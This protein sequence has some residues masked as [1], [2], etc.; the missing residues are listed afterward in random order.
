MAPDWA[1]DRR[2]E[3]DILEAVDAVEI[4]EW[5]SFWA[6]PATE[7]SR[8]ARSSRPRSTFPHKPLKVDASA[9]PDVEVAKE[10]CAGFRG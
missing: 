4:A 9:D 5:T 10:E 1:S 7:F 3:G 6:C 8:P 2:A